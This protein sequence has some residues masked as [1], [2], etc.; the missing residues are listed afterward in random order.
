MTLSRIE[1]KASHPCEEFSNEDITQQEHQEAGH[2]EVFNS[3]VW[4]KTGLPGD[5]APLVLSHRTEG[6]TVRVWQRVE[7]RGS[8]CS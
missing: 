3:Q 8:W 5:G 4:N 7:L 1:S 2:E 6:G